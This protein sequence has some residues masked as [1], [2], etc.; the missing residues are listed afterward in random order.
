VSD[1][2]PQTELAATRP[3]RKWPGWLVTGGLLLA[4]IGALLI[5]KGFDQRK[6]GI[7]VAAGSEIDCRNVVFRFDRASAQSSVNAFTQETKW[8]ILVYGTVRNPN[9][10]NVPAF[11]SST[12]NIVAT[13]PETKTTEYPKW[14]QLGAYEREPKISTRQ[15]V[16]PGDEWMPISFAFEF[17]AEYQPAATLPVSAGEMEFS[18]IALWGLGDD[19]SWNY[20]SY[21]KIYRTYLPL[22]VLA[23]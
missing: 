13:D 22:T 5:G 11:T 15:M 7:E 9:T 16:P 23:E 20:D 21:G 17:P 2:G 18:N 12:P 4:L 1:P 3:K 14:F 6:D 19:P 8:Q 10:D